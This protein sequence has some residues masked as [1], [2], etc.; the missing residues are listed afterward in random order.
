MGR[1][2]KEKKKGKLGG[3]EWAREFDWD[4]RAVIA[5]TMAIRSYGTVTYQPPHATWEEAGDGGAR[6]DF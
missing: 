1:E 4:R 5:V 2:E 6:S 3:F